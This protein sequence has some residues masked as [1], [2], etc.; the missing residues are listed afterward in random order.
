MAV[1]TDL[2]V[3]LPD[4]T[5]AK[6]GIAPVTKNHGVLRTS[7]FT[8]TI[9]NGDSITSTFEVARLPSHARISKLSKLHSTGIAGLTDNDLGPAGNPDALVDGQT[10]AAT[11]TY[12]G[13]SAITVALIDKPLWALAGLDKDP[14]EEMP[15][16]LT[17]NAA[18]TAGGSVAVDLVYIT[19]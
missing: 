19:D 13:A 17:L 18:A 11:Q 6:P 9:T 4:N 10:L 3:G 7:C 2:A 15:I 8:A 14:K 5:A 12:E 16:F 1:K